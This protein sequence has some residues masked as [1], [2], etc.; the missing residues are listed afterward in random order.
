MRRIVKFWLLCRL[1]A[2][3]HGLRYPPQTEEMKGT[4]GVASA[5]SARGGARAT[6]LRRKPGIVPFARIAVACVEHEYDV[7]QRWYPMSARLSFAW[8]RWWGFGGG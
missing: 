2:V 4:R 1:C 6:Q 5:V 3:R 8:A 7:Q